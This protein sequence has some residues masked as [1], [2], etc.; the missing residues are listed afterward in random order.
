MVRDP[1]WLHCYWELTHQAIQRAEAA[2]GD[3]WHISRPI[4]RLLDVSSRDTTSTS[5]SVLR[6]IEIHGGCN[7]WYIDVTSPPRSYRVDIG[8]LAPSRRFYALAR[9]NVVSTPRAGISDMLDE[10]W[11]DIDLKKADRIYA[12]SGG[13]DPSASSL[14]LKELFEE[15]FADLSDRPPSPALARTTCFPGRARAVSSGSSST[16]N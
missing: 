7:N 15:R 5:E 4:L 16:P 9:S 6:D 12:M 10:N 11:S 14:E 1:F 3:E 2:L 8:Y 13:Y